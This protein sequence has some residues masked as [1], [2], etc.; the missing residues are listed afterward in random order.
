MGPSHPRKITGLMIRDG[1]DCHYCGR[2]LSLDGPLYPTKD[3]IVPRSR[4]GSNRLRNLV[5][6]CMDC[7]VRKGS[8]VWHHS[9]DRCELARAWESASRPD[10]PPRPIAAR[11]TNDYGYPLHASFDG[12]EPLDLEFI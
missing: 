11:V 5:L 9:C 12:D 8:D 1:P 3:H 2:T 6:A 4:R 7:N 10:P